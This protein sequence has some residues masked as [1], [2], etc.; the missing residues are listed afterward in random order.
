MT[1]SQQLT[2]NSDTLMFDLTLRWFLTFPW[3]H[4]QCKRWPQASRWTIPQPHTRSSFLLVDLLTQTD[5]DEV[6]PTAETSHDSDSNTETN[7]PSAYPTQ[8][9]TEKHTKFPGLGMVSL[10]KCHTPSL[11]QWW[12]WPVFFGM[13]QQ[14]ARTL[15]PLLSWRI[16]E[17]GPCILR[18]LRTPKTPRN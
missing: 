15:L 16:H 12:L 17:S 4:L 2:P 18:N 9:D 11:E 13:A 5:S 7:I 3:V 6:R 1:S 10:G 8:Y 14:Q